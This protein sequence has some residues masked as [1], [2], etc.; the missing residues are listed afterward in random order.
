ML[1]YHG[2]LA[3]GKRQFARSAGGVWLAS[4]RRRLECGISR[5]LRSLAAPVQETLPP[6]LPSQTQAPALTLNTVKDGGGL[7][8]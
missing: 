6:P 7:G 5:R 4:R 1:H 2:R 3:E 8:H